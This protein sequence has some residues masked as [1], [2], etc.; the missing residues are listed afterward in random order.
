MQMIDRA[1]GAQ[2]E[3]FVG[4][5]I[6]PRGFV[7]GV[8]ENVRVAFDQAWHEGGARKIDH[9]GAGCIDAGG[10]TGSFDTRSVD[11]N[12]PAFVRFGAVEH[13]G[14]AENGLGRSEAGQHEER[15]GRES[16][17]FAIIDGVT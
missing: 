8:E 4:H 15:K 10:W 12:G 16:E 13:S 6:V 17:H 9:L 14:R 1:G 3:T 2:C 7:V 5:L 11:A